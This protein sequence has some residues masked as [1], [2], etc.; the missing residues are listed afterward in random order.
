MKLKDEVDSLC[1]E[2]FQTGEEGIFK[3]PRDLFIAKKVNLYGLEFRLFDPRDYDTADNRIRF[4]FAS[5]DSCPSINGLLVY[6]E[7]HKECCKYE[8]SL[9]KDADLFLTGLHVHLRYYAE[10]WMD[11]LLGYIKYFYIPNLYYWRYDDLS[12]YDR[13]LKLVS[14]FGGKEAESKI[15]NMLKEGLKDEID[16]WSRLQA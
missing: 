2:I 14:E 5:I 11:K 4:V 6:V 12:G 8:N 16:S 9:I 3:E 1:Q 15:L 10:H 13:L 7:D